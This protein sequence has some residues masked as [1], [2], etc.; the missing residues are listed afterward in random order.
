VVVDMGEPLF[1][2]VDCL[3][4]AVPDLAAALAFY[5]DGLG[6]ELIWRSSTAAGLRLPES[7]AEIVLHTEGL[8]HGG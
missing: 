6:H 2:R 3:R 7:S 4:I 1:R 5:R 8:R